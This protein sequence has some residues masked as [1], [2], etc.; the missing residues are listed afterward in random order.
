MADKTL[1]EAQCYSENNCKLGFHV[2]G[3]D[4]FYTSTQHGT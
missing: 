2:Q 1:L 3:D 4:D